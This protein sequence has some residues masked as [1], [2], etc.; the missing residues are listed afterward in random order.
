MTTSTAEWLLYFSNKRREIPYQTQEVDIIN[1]LPHGDR[2]RCGHNPWIYARKVSNLIIEVNE[3]TDSE[4]LTWQE[5][6]V[7]RWKD[8]NRLD[9]VLDRE[10]ATK[11]L[12]RRRSPVLNFPH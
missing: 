1:K 3:A 9:I 10:G 12:E 2:I 7:F 6:R 11:S 5:P 8:E 4:I